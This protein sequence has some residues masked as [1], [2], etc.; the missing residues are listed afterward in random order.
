M[1]RRSKR[2][3]QFIARYVSFVL[4]YTIAET[5][6]VAN[7]IWGVDDDGGKSEENE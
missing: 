4:E 2:R 7:E 1:R 6:V 3:T 5:R